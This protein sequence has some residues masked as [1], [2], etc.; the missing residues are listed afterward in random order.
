MYRSLTEW[1]QKKF[2]PR[3]TGSGVDAS[4]LKSPK[5]KALWQNPME[6]E[7]TETS[8]PGDAK[9]TEVGQAFQ[10]L[11]EYLQ[12][13]LRRAESTRTGGAKG[14]GLVHLE[15]GLLPG[16]QAYIYCQAVQNKGI[17]ICQTTQGWQL[18]SAHKIIATE[19]FVR[20][21]NLLDYCQV[22]MGT[23]PLSSHGSASRNARISSELF[24]QSSYAPMELYLQ[25]LCALLK[26][27]H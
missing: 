18:F 13:E 6:H 20:S 3:Q 1:I 12:M 5:A 19:T 21:A 2:R 23:L 22:E 11:W 9:A 27:L 17:L 16:Q 7:A 14:L 25:K 8:A 26:E 24:F 4:L 10:R 15:K